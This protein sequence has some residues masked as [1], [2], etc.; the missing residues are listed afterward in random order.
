MQRE[1]H[2]FLDE[3]AFGKF[4]KIVNPLLLMRKTSPSLPVNGYAANEFLSE[5]FTQDDEWL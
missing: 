3:L 1:T 5:H 4:L 2:I